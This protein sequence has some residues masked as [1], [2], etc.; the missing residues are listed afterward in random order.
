MAI[1]YGRAEAEKDLL[2][3]SPD[4]VKK[5]EDLETIHQELKDHL[6]NNKKKFVNNLPSKIKEDEAELE[7]IKKVEKKILQEYDEKIKNLENK[8]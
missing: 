6:S 8:K 7:K 5:V 3:I 1:I 2:S 4:S